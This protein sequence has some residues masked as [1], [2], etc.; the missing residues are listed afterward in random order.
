MIRLQPSSPIASGIVVNRFMIAFL[1]GTSKEERV[2]ESSLSYPQPSEL[3]CHK[4]KVTD[5]ISQT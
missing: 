2:T 5:S 4:L 1:E 3:R